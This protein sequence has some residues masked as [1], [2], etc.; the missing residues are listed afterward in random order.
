MKPRWLIFIALFFKLS[1]AFAM[2]E[3]EVEA[4]T[5]FINTL[6]KTS[7]IHKS[8]SFCIFGSDEISSALMFGDAKIVDLTKSPEKFNLC[9][10]IYIASGS[11]KSLKLEIAKFNN[12]NIMT[13]GIF[14]G[15][16]E[17]GGMVQ[18]QMDRRNFEMIVNPK[19]I[20]ESNIKINSLLTNLII[21]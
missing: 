16:T 17:I 10:A 2:D 13:V 19:A 9:K 21:N 11:E 15:F 1:S 8:G 4:F 12:A 3:G 18:V 6:V 7:S 14:E 5:D 20:K